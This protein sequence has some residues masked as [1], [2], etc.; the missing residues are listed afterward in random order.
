M[1]ENN[2][3]MKMLVGL[4]NMGAS[5]VNTRHNLGQFVVDCFARAHNCK[6]VNNKKLNADLARMRFGDKVLVLARPL[7]FMNHSGYPVKRIADYFRIPAS[8]IIVVYDEI[9]VALGEFK[10]TYRLGD[11]GHNGMADVAAKVGECVRFRVGIGH[12]TEPEMDLKDYVLGK[13]S[14]EEQAAITYHMPAILKGI[15]STILAES[16]RNGVALEIN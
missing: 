9:N 3:S 5:Y 10:V 14:D 4:G 7:S 15:E 13:F 6:W 2:G 8:D 12:K 16:P 1:V 11:G